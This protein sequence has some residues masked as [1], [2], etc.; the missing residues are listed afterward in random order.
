MEFHVGTTFGREFDIDIARSFG[1]IEQIGTFSDSDTITEIQ[2]ATGK[3]IVTS[4]YKRRIRS[5]KSS[6]SKCIITCLIRII[7]NQRRCKFFII[8]CQLIEIPC[9]QIIDFGKP[10]R[11]SQIAFQHD[12]V[13]QIGISVAPTIERIESVAIGSQCNLITDEILVFHRIDIYFGRL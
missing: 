3:L 8:L 1:F 10:G 6:I 7:S 9:C 4:A 11:Y 13:F 2:N 12:F 5:V